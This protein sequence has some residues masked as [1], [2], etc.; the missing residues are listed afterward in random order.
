MSADADDIR[1]QL[2]AGLRHALQM[3]VAAVWN[4]VTLGG[5]QAPGPRFK[6][7]V[8]KAVIFY[9]QAVTAVEKMKI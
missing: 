2:L 7:G 8:T 4:N 6:E 1:A 9:Q 5:E 3:R